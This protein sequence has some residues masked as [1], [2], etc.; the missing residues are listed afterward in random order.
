MSI[1]FQTIFQ[2]S[3]NIKATASELEKLYSAHEAKRA[4]L[5]KR[6]VENAEKELK[7]IQLGLNQ[8]EKMLGDSFSRDIQRLRKLKNQLTTRRADAAAGGKIDSGSLFHESLQIERKKLDLFA[9]HHENI[10]KLIRHEETR[11]L[12]A[13]QIFHL[14]TPQF[15]KFSQIDFRD[16][17]SKI[18]KERVFRPPYPFLDGQII[19]QQGSDA[20]VGNPDF[21]RTQV[22][23][24]HRD[25]KTLT[26][27]ENLRFRNTTDHDWAWA[28]HYI[29]FSF[30]VRMPRDGF[31]RIAYQVRVNE[32]YRRAGFY[33]EIGFS[34][35]F[36]HQR[37][38]IAASAAGTD[39]V[40]RRP[41]V[42]DS[43]NIIDEVS[44]SNPSILPNPAHRQTMLPEGSGLRLI[45]D[46]PEVFKAG[47]M[48]LVSIGPVVQTTLEA[49]DMGLDSEIAASF[50]IERVAVEVVGA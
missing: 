10:A 40:S 25:G 33:D 9:V 29:A 21:D 28:H 30:P 16:L 39:I 11:R 1:H 35:G 8:R 46:T 42:D 7:L 34:S 36:I 4:K 45:Q 5:Y 24:H 38:A 26:L 13:P 44:W 3:G 31:L 19:W 12:A 6:L 37:L 18:P 32:N 50:E 14:L 48:V 43:I 47:S 41:G 15:K 22:H 17:L 27:A 20:I 2:Q 49:D 23:E